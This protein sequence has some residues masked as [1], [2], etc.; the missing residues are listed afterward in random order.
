MK[1]GIFSYDRKG[2]YNLVFRTYKLIIGGNLRVA[3][4][5][6]GRCVNNGF[7]EEF[8]RIIKSKCII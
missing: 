2:K 5:L 1:G 8:W 7:T 3:S 6:V 4:I